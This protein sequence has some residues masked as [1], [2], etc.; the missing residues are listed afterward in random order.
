MRIL[1]TGSC[2]FIG[3]TLVDYLINKGHQVVGIDNLSA[4]S[5][6]QFYFNDK[7]EYYKYSVTDSVMC[8]DVFKRHNFDYVFHLAAEARIQRCIEDPSS[9][10]ETNTMGTEVML[11]LSQKYEVSRFV[12]MSTSAIYGLQ[13]ENLEGDSQKETDTP[14]CLNAYSYSKW[15]GESLCK[16][17][18]KL[19][20]LDTVCFRG[21]NIYG[22]RQPK[23][24]QY[25]PVMG[26]FLRQIKNKEALTIVGD[27][28]QKRDFIHVDDVCS[29]LY[30]GATDHKIQNGEVYN[31]GT[32]S[33]NSIVEIADKMAKHY[34]HDLQHIYL[35]P[36]IGE[37]RVTLA[38][39]SKTKFKLNWKPEI[40]VEEWISKQ[41]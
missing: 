17:Y 9:C 4:D 25:A 5:H 23:K 39:I 14:D 33:N 40:K 30:A 20:N 12:F 21:F 31:I 6:D 11:S 13:N 35:P 8:S 28:L 24:G 3:S 37:A 34:K 15:F 2:G 19:Y 38:D 18:S 10:L 32:G 1:V 26:I 29:A 41:D 16:M 7:A 36:R 27:G 22:N